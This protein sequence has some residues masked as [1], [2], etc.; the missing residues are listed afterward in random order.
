MTLD[1]TRDVRFFAVARL[2]ASYCGGDD[3]FP[4][5]RALAREFEGVDDVAF[6]G[7]GE[8]KQAGVCSVEPVRFMD[9][10]VGELRVFL[11]ME[12]FRES[13]PAPLTRF[14]AKQL[15]NAVRSAAIHASNAALQEHL[16]GLEAEV[17]ERKLLDR[18]RGVI[19]SRK[20][21]PAGEGER[22]LKKLSDQSG[23]NLRDLAKGIVTTAAKNPWKFRREF[24]A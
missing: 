24:C 10:T 18:A 23:R 13:S 22:L 19:E 6:A 12:A 20:L 9:E 3:F 16:A 4:R 15:G 11:N 21:I 14:L 2:C 8:D 1:F 5:F 7:L 17:H